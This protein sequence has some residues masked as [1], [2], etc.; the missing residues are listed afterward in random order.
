MELRLSQIWKD[1]GSPVE[2]VV[3]SDGR[4]WAPQLCQLGSGVHEGSVQW[5]HAE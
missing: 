1:I 2:E 5:Q 4:W 3:I